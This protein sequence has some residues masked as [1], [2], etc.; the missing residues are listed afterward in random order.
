VRKKAGPFQD[1]LI[2]LGAGLRK[3]AK[4]KIQKAKV[5]RQNSKVKSQKSK[6]KS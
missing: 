5:K 3:K 2:F 6:G 4:G 1:W